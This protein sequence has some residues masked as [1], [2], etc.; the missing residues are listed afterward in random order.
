MTRTVTRS[1]ALEPAP[2]CVP[3]STPAPTSTAAAI[4]S[5]TR[6]PMG[7]ATPTST[8]PCGVR[9]SLCSMSVPPIVVDVGE[10]VGVGHVELG[11]RGVAV[12]V[13]P[14]APARRHQQ[15]LAL[16]SFLDA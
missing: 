7:I 9:S 6:Q 3:T 13:D 4:A 14:D 1:G 12:Q 16:A 10:D 15:P 11:R 2:M 8:L 5:G